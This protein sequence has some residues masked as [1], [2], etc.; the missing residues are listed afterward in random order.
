MS[1]ILV[2]AVVGAIIGY[3]TNYIAIKMLFKPHKEKRILGF[4]VPFTPGLIPKEKTR[5]AKSVGETISNHLINYDTIKNSLEDKKIKVYFKDIIKDKILSFKNEDKT[6]LEITEEIGIFKY[7]DLDNLSNKLLDYIYNSF[8]DNKINNNIVPIIEQSIK[9]KLMTKPDF[10]K[11]LIEKDEFK[12]NIDSFLKEFLGDNKNEEKI[13]SIVKEN[14]KALEI[15][16]KKI[17]DV[18]PKGTI[19]ALEKYIYDDR[20]NICNNLKEL[21]LKEE[22]KDQLKIVIR[23][24]VLNNLSPLIAMFLNEESLYGKF[25]SVVDD[26]LSEEEN[27]IMIVNLINRG[28]KNTCQKEISVILKEISS[29]SMDNI[30]QEIS[31]FILNRIKNNIKNEDIIGF[32]GEKIGAF[33]NYDEIISK[34]YNRY[35]EKINLFITKS[36]NNIKNSIKVKSFIKKEIYNLLLFV[37]DKKIS[38][39]VSNK[40]DDIVSVSFKGI[41]KLYDNFINQGLYKI[42]NLLNIESIIENQINSFEVDYAEKII[43]EIANKELKAITWLG[44]LLGGILGILSPILASIY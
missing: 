10:L 35:D 44:A 38:E 27:K 25:I 24:K 40:E 12:N 39:I 16:N 17:K 43:L 29:D 31:K 26:Y 18:V 42:L 33:N 23:N 32:L 13:K 41:D 5:I 20:D 15:S 19:E 14:F 7:D 3:I 34:F 28:I 8:N 22:V 36:I 21:L 1:K 11:K 9:T 4:K 6:I 2:G 30:S 37:G